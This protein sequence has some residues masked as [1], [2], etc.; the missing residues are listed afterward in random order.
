M[1]P[2]KE[3]CGKKDF[4][5]TKDITDIFPSSKAYGKIS[6]DDDFEIKVVTSDR[7]EYE[8][9]G[10]SIIQMLPKDV[11]LNV[12]PKGKQYSGDNSVDVP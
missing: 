6:Q 7:C 3:E 2:T 5:S 1:T 8:I 10:E 12:K 11:K 9:A 4:I